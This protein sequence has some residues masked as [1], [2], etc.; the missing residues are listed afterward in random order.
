MK[1]FPLEQRTVHYF[2]TCPDALKRNKELALAVVA[3]GKQT[4]TPVSELMLKKG[5]VTCFQLLSLPDLPRP[6]T[7]AAEYVDVVPGAADFPISDTS[8]SYAARGRVLTARQRQAVQRSPSK[9]VQA[10]V[11]PDDEQGEG[12]SEPAAS[13]GAATPSAVATPPSG[14]RKS[15]ASAG[16]GPPASSLKKMKQTKEPHDET[17]E[18]AEEATAGPSKTPAKTTQVTATS[19]ADAA[20]PASGAKRKKGAMSATPK[21][22]GQRGTQSKASTP[23]DRADKAGG[24]TPDLF[25]LSNL[26]PKERAE[27]DAK[28]AVEAKEGGDAGEDSAQS[29]STSDSSG[30]D[31]EEDTSDDNAVASRGAA[32][33]A[34]VLKATAPKSIVKPAGDVA[35]SGA[36]A[37]GSQEPSA[38]PQSTKGQ[39]KK[40]KSPAAKQT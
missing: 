10:I 16:A 33:A 8:A 25:R 22:V 40:G 13:Q 1:C 2:G 38:Q 6:A 20:A 26:A 35:A 11:V 3:D 23:D 19:P 28:L 12:G 32:A 4:W 15:T 5:K 7:L 27:F 24:G 9:V 14:K 29:D 21:R 34:K 31:S 18:S 36:G 30:S 37:A 17:P 39:A